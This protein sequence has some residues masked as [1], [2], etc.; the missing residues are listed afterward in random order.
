MRRQ[1]ASKPVSAP[2]PSRL[3]LAGAW[4]GIALLL[5]GLLAWYLSAARR[6]A[7]EFGLPLDDG[8]IHARFAQ[9]LARGEGFSF[10]PGEATSTTTSPL[11]TLLLALGYRVTGE[12][13]FT[14]IAINYAL[15]LALLVIVYR[16]SLAL[17][18]SRWL[19]LSVALAL[20]VTVPLQWWALSGMEPTLYAALALLG[21][22]LHITAR[23][24]GPARELPA[25]VVF[26]LA[27]LARPE[28]LLL[29]PLAMLDRLLSMRKRSFVGW[30]K[31][32]ALNFPIYALFVTPFLFYNHRVTGYLLP[33]S[34]YSKL[35]YA[36]IPGLL[37]GAPISPLA[38]IVLYPLGELASVIGVWLK[39]NFI[40]GVSVFAGAGWLVWQW[41][42]NS[43]SGRRSLLVPLLLVVQPLAWAMAGG[44]RPPAYQSQR[45]LAD[46]NPLFVLLGMIGGWWATGRVPG[47]WRDRARV[48]LLGAV[49]AVSLVG[50]PEG[51]MTYA[52]NVKNTTEMQVAI[53]R[54]LKA[55]APADSLLAVNDIGA[56]GSITQMRVLDL[57]G[58]VTP[59][60]LPLRDMR[61]RLDGTAPMK[62]F[63]FIV[64][65]RPG[66]LV[67]FPQ[68]YPELAA[69]TDLF[70]QVHSVVLT[71]NITNG[72]S[73]MVIYRTIWAGQGK[74][75]SG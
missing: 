37:S 38:A 51:L 46:L 15:T 68:W 17:I 26:S 27:A 3:V 70:T 24:D 34:Y 44:Y 32:L 20:A 55:N 58:L 25:T 59:E 5:A 56:I 33:T 42:K 43:D 60:V 18:P 22:L 14:G 65:R 30:L 50:Q 73:E 53:G 28:M 11:W 69:R 9:H 74:G 35:Q 23:S 4:L 7:G 39:D 2:E 21:I 62:M 61:S 1:K 16:L 45:Y 49:L 75:P 40:L 10:N 6:A 72:A 52:R 12:Y 48:A 57:Q 47:A 54:W 19:A 36:G 67:I 64:S 66:Y 31:E 29:F 41:R 63:E 13:L 71:D 8:W